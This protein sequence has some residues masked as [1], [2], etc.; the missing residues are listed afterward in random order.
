MIIEIHGAHTV[1][2]GRATTKFAALHTLQC[3]RA[4][5]QQTAAAAAEAEAAAAAAE[6]RGRV[7]QWAVQATLCGFAVSQ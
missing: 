3:S 2:S 1:M 6:R 4:A 5:L 7:P